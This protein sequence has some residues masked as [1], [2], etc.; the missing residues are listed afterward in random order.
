MMRKYDKRINRTEVKRPW[1]YTTL[2]SANYFSFRYWWLILLL[3]TGLLLLWYFLCFRGICLNNRT[4]TE[5][6]KLLQK[7]EQVDNLIDKC[8]DCNSSIVLDD[9]LNN[10]YRQITD[11]IRDS[12]GGKI[13]KVTVTLSW[14]TLDDL[15]LYLFEPTGEVIHFNNN[16]SPSGGRLDLDMNYG[17]NTS[18]YPIENIYYLGDP[19]SGRYQVYVQLYGKKSDMNAIPFTVQVR[20]QDQVFHFIDSIRTVGQTHFI[21]EFFYP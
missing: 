21:H 1:W 17:S 9:S 10:H 16:S 5:Y 2:R 7:V 8:C 3:F 14:S 20:K 11:N 6:S 12:L 18:L 19:P 13:G 15:D 4:C